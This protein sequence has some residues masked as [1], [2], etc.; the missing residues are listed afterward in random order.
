M[1]LPVAHVENLLIRMQIKRVGMLRACC[2]YGCEYAVA[3][4]LPL[5]YDYASEQRGAHRYFSNKR[6]ITGEYQVVMRDH[7][8]ESDR[9]L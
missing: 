7:N 1:T 2:A 3:T 4:A 5:V 9:F 6:Y 8:Y